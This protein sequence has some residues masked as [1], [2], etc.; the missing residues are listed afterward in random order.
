MKNLKEFKKFNIDE[1]K[2]D[3]INTTIT[4]S[5]D[6]KTYIWSKIEYTKK[7]KAT[8]NKSDLFKLLTSKGD[9]NIP[10]EQFIGILD[11]LEYTI[12]KQMTDP[13]K[14]FKNELATSIKAKLP[15]EWMGVKYTII[16]RKKEEKTE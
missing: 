15:T 3:N 1:S 13:E 6:E 4:L 11:N 5:A 8:E 14:K 9:S 16:S 7:K 2:K 10:V 12:K